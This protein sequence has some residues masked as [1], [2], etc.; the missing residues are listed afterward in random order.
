MHEVLVNR[1]RGLRLP[2]KSVVRL[3]DLPDITLDVLNVDVKQHNGR[4]RK[5]QHNDN[6]S[7]YY[8]LVESI[9]RHKMLKQLPYFFS[10][11]TGRSLPKRSQTTSSVW[12]DGYLCGCFG[13]KSTFY[14]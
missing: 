14:S 4:G 10:Y 8:K 1:L 13:K 2:S 3:T 6:K 9:S 12:S 7:E 11:K 5:L